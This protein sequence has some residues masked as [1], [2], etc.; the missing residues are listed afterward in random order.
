[1]EDVQFGGADMVDSLKLFI[2]PTV[3]LVSSKCDDGVLDRLDPEM[4]DG[5]AMSVDGRSTDQTRLPYLLECRPNAEFGYDAARNK[6][7]NLRIGQRDGPR[8]TFVVPGDVVAETDNH[9][10]PEHSFAG[11]QG[12]LLR[13]SGWINIESRTTVG[14]AGAV[15]SHLQRRRAAAYLPGDRGAAAMFRVTTVEMFSLSGMMFVNS[16]TLLSLQITSTES[17]P[18][19]GPASS[20]GW[21]S[22]TKEGLSVYGLFHQLA[23][24]A[25]GRALLKQYFLRPSLNIHVINERLNTIDVLLLPE[26]T[27]CL[28]RLVASLAK[29]KNMRISTVNLRKGTSSGLNKNRGISTSVWPN[30]RNF[31]YYALRITDV[32]AETAGA[33]RLALCNKI[34]ETFDKKQL[35]AVGKLINDVVDFEASKEECRTVVQAGV[36]PDLDEAKR[37][38]QGIEDLLSQV[39]GHIADTVPAELNS[40]VNVI[41]FPQIGFLISICNDQDT[42]RGI[43]EGTVDDPWEKMFNTE[44]CAYYKNSNMTE[45]DQHFGDIYGQICDKEIE[46]VQQLGE[47]VL[48]YEELLNAVSDICGELDSFV[49]L[50]RGARD[51]NLCRPR[52]TEENVV[53][54]K[55]GRHPLQELT[56][57]NYVPN[58]TLMVGGAGRAPED[59]PQDAITSQ[60]ARGRTSQPAA[61]HAATGPSTVMMTGPNY[62]G[63][64]VYLKQVAV[65]VYMAHIGCFV[66]AESAKIGLTDKILTRISTRES[67]SR[68][69]SAFMI[70]LQQI[71][72]AL[73]LATRRSLVVIDEFGKGTESYD[74]AGLAAGVFEHL[75]GRG[76]ESPK[77]LGATHFHEI[78]ETGFLPPRPELAF[79]HMQ[80]QVDRQAQEV[81]HQITYLYQYQSGRSGSS[82]GTVCAAINGIDQAIVAR[83]EELTDLA[84]RGEDLVEALAELPADELAELDDA[85]NIARDFLEVDVHDQPRKILDDIV[86]LASST[87]GG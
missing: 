74:G 58:D 29:V 56:V 33:H 67:V 31:V 52:I 10:D 6:L 79:A 4:R 76:A 55:K 22:A 45:M 27:T 17:H 48:E 39:A 13:L 23:K 82:Y 64:S 34:L 60:D 15:L 16:D 80:V 3:I 26:N 41:F 37:T 8:V 35:S 85:E 24:T 84:N 62:S 2:D 78:F 25:Q 21:T 7:V 30:I 14:C 18:N 53:K 51:Y 86:T 65:I 83:A 70:D 57:T 75:L 71:S 50:A 59:H 66:P 77:V 47:R 12:A 36:D 28:D 81:N 68:V 43:F 11:H 87:H 46:I 49:A 40:M 69:Q 61:R 20:K 42:G 5:R 9:D 44:E 73:S 72:V 38:Y 54:I 19:L 32:L 1:M 63:K